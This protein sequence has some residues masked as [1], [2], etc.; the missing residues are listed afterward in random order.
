M[1][2]F[3]P[4]L[5]LQDSADKFHLFST[6]NKPLFSSGLILWCRLDILFVYSEFPL[7]NCAVIYH[8]WFWLLFHLGAESLWAEPICSH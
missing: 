5:Q 1:W 8:L 7:L 2:M 4:I 3:S 6:R